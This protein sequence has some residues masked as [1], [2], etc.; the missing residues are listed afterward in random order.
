MSRTGTPDDRGS[1]QFTDEEIAAVIDHYDDPEHPDALD[2]SEV[3]ALLANVQRT[4]ETGW[5]DYLDGIRCG[6][7]AVVFDSE[8]VAVFR[9][10]ERREWNSLLDEIALF[11]QV[12]RT[13]LRVTHHQAAKRLTDRTFDGSDAIVVR[14]PNRAMAGQRFVEAVV[15]SLLRK[16]VHPK[17]AWAY[18]GID[19]R[20]I[21]GEAWV[22]R[23]GYEDK[24]EVADAVE[25]ARDELGR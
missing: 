18:Y 13:I 20:G 3:R 9:D 5:A 15:D 25:T 24:I 7:L 14:K 16:G 1:E 11:D 2:I 4:L 21:S 6:D 8:D 17:D 19:I 10:D 12:D 22:E 23:A